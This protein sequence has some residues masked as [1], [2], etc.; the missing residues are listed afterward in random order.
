MTEKSSESMKNNLLIQNSIFFFIWV[1]GTALSMK[2]WAEKTDFPSVISIQWVYEVIFVYSILS[3]LALCIKTR[4]FILWIPTS[5]LL[6]WVGFTIGLVLF[7]AFALSSFIPPGVGFA[8]GGAILGISQ[9]LLI[10]EYPKAYLIIYAQALSYWIVWPL[11]VL[12]IFSSSD[13]YTPTPSRTDFISLIEGK[14]LLLALL[15][16]ATLLYIFKSSRKS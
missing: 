11:I 3:G 5:I 12:T 13:P 2:F 16:G 6:G 15:N 7:Y 9:Y 8:I 1:F 4:K 10:R 14:G